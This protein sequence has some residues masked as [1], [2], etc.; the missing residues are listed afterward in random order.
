MKELSIDEKTKVHSKL[1]FFIGD[2]I[3]FLTNDRTFLIHDKR[4]LLVPNSLMKC[5]SYRLF[6]KI[7]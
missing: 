2:N 3:Q 7:T 6:L 5:L 1:K 4:V